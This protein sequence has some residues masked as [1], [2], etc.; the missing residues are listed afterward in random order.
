MPFKIDKI[1]FG[2]R[3]AKL[4]EKSTM[5]RLELS[6]KCGLHYSSIYQLEIGKHSPDMASVVQLAAALKVSVDK[7]L[8]T[9][10]ECV[11]DGNVKDGGKTKRKA[12]TKVDA[13]PNLP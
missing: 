5:T 10:E 13:I 8:R 4:R 1:A 12:K 2:K 11:V 3:L 7:M 6:R 9:G